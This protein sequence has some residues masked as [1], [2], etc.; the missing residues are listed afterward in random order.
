MK[1]MRTLLSV[2]LLVVLAVALVAC[3]GRQNAAPSSETTSGN[4]IVLQNFAFNPASLTVKVGDTVTF[5]NA[6]QVPHHI[7]VG[8][9]DLGIQ[10]P[11]QSVTWKAPSDG[12]YMLKCLIHPS[13]RGQITVGSGGSTI[14][15]APAGGAMPGGGTTGSGTTG[16]YGY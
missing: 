10:Q 12:V 11:G 16:G 5:R 14:G 2:S 8:T 9:D 7:V 15:T 6:D 13:M 1:N 3:S 4:T